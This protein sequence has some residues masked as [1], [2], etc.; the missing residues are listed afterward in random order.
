MFIFKTE[1]MEKKSFK[2]LR[3]SMWDFTSVP[4]YAVVQCLNP[5]T[6]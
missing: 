6:T 4:P 1:K 5:W 2:V 3:L